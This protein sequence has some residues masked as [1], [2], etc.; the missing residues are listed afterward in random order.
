[1]KHT[2]GDCECLQ[3]MMETTYESRGSDREIRNLGTLSKIPTTLSFHAT[4]LSPI[5][6]SPARF[7]IHIVKPLEALLSS[8]REQGITGPQKSKKQKKARQNDN[9]DARAQRAAVLAGIRESFNPFEY[10]TLSRPKKFEY[11]TNK[12]QD[13]KK[14]LGRPGVTKSQGEETRRKTLLPEMNRRNKVGGILDRRIG[15]NDPSMSLD[16]RM[17]ARFER[18]QQSRKG[19]NVFD[20]EEA[21]DEVELTH[22]GRSLNFD[23][24]G[25]DYDA[26]SVEVSSDGEASSFLQR[27]RRRD[28]DGEI[29]RVGEP[30]EEQPERKKSKAEVMKEV[31][32]K[33]KLHKYERQQLKEDDDELREEL[34]KDLPDVL[35]ALRSHLNKTAPT[36]EPPKDHS[37]NDFSMN[38][39]RAALLAGKD[40]DAAD[41]EY[42]A[43]VRQMLYDQRSK[44]TER[45]KTEEEKAKEE[46]DRLKELE[47][48]RMRRMKGEPDSESED[49][50]KPRG[51]AES[52]EEVV[53]DDAA[54]FGLSTVLVQ[55][56]RPDGVDD[57][58]DF[59][60]DDDLIASDSEADISEASDEESNQDN[61][62]GVDEDDE[63][64]RDILPAKTESGK[65]TNGILSITTEPKSSKLAYTY[66]CPQSHEELLQVFKDISH[67]DI[68]TVVQRIRALYHAGLH[69][70][71]KTKL[72]DFAC[73]LVDHVSYL[74]CQT[75]SAPL[76]VIETLIRHIHSLSRSYPVQ[77]ATRFRHHLKQ[78]QTSNDPTPGDLTIL[79]AIGSIYPTSDH[80]HQVATPAITLMARWL[81]LTTPSSTKDIATGAY[82][83]ALCIHYIR[84]SKRYIPELMRYTLLCLKS[85]H[86]TPTLTTALTKN[87]LS[88]ADLWTPFPSFTE[89][90]SPTLPIL[91]ALSGQTHAIQRLTILLRQSRLHRRPQTLHFH[92]PLPIKSSIPKFEESFD[93]NKHYD[94]DRERAE[95]KRLQKEYKRERKGALREL[96]KDANFI[97]REKLREK[98]EKDRAY[99]EK[100]RK[101]VASIQ[102]EEGREKNDYER[103]RRKRKMGRDADASI[104]T[105]MGLGEFNGSI[106]YTNILMCYCNMSI[107][108]PREIWVFSISNGR[109]FPEPNS[110]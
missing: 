41:K 49:E 68:P 100:Y 1:M 103:E 54:E 89:I 57:E 37:N 18:E 45:T 75:P 63:F 92:R 16:D 73:A 105:Q 78:L 79:T 93:P 52:E 62:M 109:R 23:E 86:L 58:D 3:A 28:S 67:G 40:R 85:P 12:P 95:S 21:D 10:K 36:P 108:I 107:L 22:G 80:F 29:E 43:R 66:P 20:L 88:L 5:L 87:I 42:D 65:P 19:A 84:L 102:E 82:I 8:L 2:S 64:L 71:N 61:T 55:G 96:R 9:S 6:F 27:K 101:L 32:A 14:V 38:P 81:G 94:P 99:A 91:T 34:D 13:A 53:T 106:H 104:C 76:P 72:A 33:S 70:D 97:A 50:Q 110:Y 35:V 24:D 11:T 69:A 77:I 15:E 17:M 60:V 47:E 39:D 31:I 48:K 90:F 51:D 46:A 25:E 30:E 7:L 74:S 26:A 4:L 56:S 98:K 44:P 83:G 59:M